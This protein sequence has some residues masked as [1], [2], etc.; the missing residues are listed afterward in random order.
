MWR[1]D[2]GAGLGA[3]LSRRT[4]AISDTMRSVGAAAE[5]ARGA[6]RIGASIENVSTQYVVTRS[7]TAAGADST[8]RH[9]TLRASPAVVA[10]YAERR[11]SDTA[12]ARTAVVG[13]R[14]SDVLGGAMGSTPL[15][16]PH[17][18]LVMPI[19]HAVRL[20]VGYAR[21]HQVV[22]SVWSTEPVL[23]QIAPVALPVAARAGSVPVLTGD[24]VSASVRAPVT[25]RLTLDVAAFGR[26]FHGMLVPAESEA[27]GASAVTTAAGRAAGASIVA[28]GD[29]AGIS[30]TTSYRVTR[31]VS[32]APLAPGLGRRETSHDLALT[33]GAHV[34][35][36]TELHI[37]GWLGTPER[38]GEG[39]VLGRA[40]HDDAD[41]AGE[42]D[43]PTAARDRVSAASAPL[44][45]RAPRYSRLDLT[46]D[47]R[48]S[49]GSL[50]ALDGV[51]TLANVLG[52]TNT[53][54]ALPDPGE[55]A[56]GIRFTPRSILLGIA[57][58]QR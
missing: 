21:T 14:A 28:R 1:S 16:E 56:H 51:L 54:L 47:R 58:R 55:A 25:S 42:G 33:L 40:G 44:F 10:A 4:M 13:L 45:A 8:L 18:A 39:D 46:L 6:A 29:V 5:L 20:G 53:A 37:D 7:M 26:D 31:T 48:W 11:W 41:A 34:G 38:P 23:S 24:V 19:A 3:S 9:S 52:H 15:L 43:V 27:G 57:W 35:K 12:S 32:S 50:G 49:L 17:V 30:W 22:Q 36:L 2:F